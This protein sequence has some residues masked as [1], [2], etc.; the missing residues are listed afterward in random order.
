MTFSEGETPCVWV[1]CKENRDAE[2]GAEFQER[3]FC[4]TLYKHRPS[5]TRMQELISEG[6]MKEVQV[7]S[8]RLVSSLKSVVGFSFPLAPR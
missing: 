7:I 8:L 2:M 3:A 1:T 6:Q 5:V 4:G